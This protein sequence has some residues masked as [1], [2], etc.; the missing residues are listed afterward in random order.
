MSDRI[1][2]QSRITSGNWRK[3]QNATN[4]TQQILQRM[5]EVKSMH[6]NFRAVDEP[7]RAIDILRSER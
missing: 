3:S 6:R 4:N 5:K 1:E 2:I 7:G